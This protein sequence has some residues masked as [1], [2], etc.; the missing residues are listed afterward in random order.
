MTTTD[1]PRWTRWQALAFAAVLVLAAVLRLGWAGVNSFAF[2]EARLS[3]ISLDMARDGVFAT[4]GMPS[5]AGVPN[6]PA[7]AWIYALPY[8]LSP[9]PLLATLFTGV[10]GVV[11]V[12]L[13]GWLARAAWGAWASVAAALFLA[14]S[15]F[16]VLYS[17]SIWAPDLLP[18]LGIVWA[19][20]AYKA[21]Q[22]GSAWALA[23]HIFVAGFA[24]QVHFAGAALALGS[25]WLVLRF[26]WWR[27]WRPLL[28]GAVLAGVA[29]LPFALE[30]L[31]HRPDVLDA[32]RSASGGAQV[33][34]GAFTALAQ[35]AAGQGWGYMITGQRDT[36]SQNGL[37]AAGSLLLCGV[38][39]VALLPLRRRAQDAPLP[40]ITLVLLLSG[41]VF[42]TRHSTPVFIH[43]LLAAMPALALMV[44]A[45]VT[46][47]HGRWVRAALAVLL[48]CVCGTAALWLGE[49]ITLGGRVE[50]P[51][52]LG[53]PLGISRGVAQTV[54]D[55]RVALFFTHGGD[56][57]RDG[58]AAVFAAL[59]YT[60]PHRIIG[61]DS[62]LLLPDAPATLV[63]TLE[64]FQAWEEL[65]AAGLA[66]DVQYY[67]RRE[68]EG[69][70]PFVMTAYDGQA[71]PQGF[72]L[73]QP[74]VAFA[75]GTRLLGWKVRRVGDRLRLSTL[76][77]A[78]APQAVGTMQQFHH[79]RDNATLDGDFRMGSDVPLQLHLWQ[80]GDRAVVMADFAAGD[81]VALQGALWVG[82][83]HYALESGA[84]VTLTSG[85][86]HVRLGPFDL[87]PAG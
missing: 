3:L 12:A 33:D 67:P 78:D 77:A 45:A 70:L 42:F 8:A 5:S 60:R 25:L 9:D 6:L 87:P 4:I 49:S 30:V 62:L 38:G 73:L 50:T 72:T 28:I 46:R 71:A 83:G 10:L 29:A 13:T 15:P 32:F 63:G 41:A 76:W 34:G 11:A 54:P 26:G 85:G 19:A 24:F 18:V 59:W 40:E 79:L 7:A 39:L 2:D 1:A 74:E 52:G 20:A 66:D 69:V 43:Y 37:Y 31:L 65:V 16:A 68:G 44:G 61:G 86:D 58:E 56:P 47:W 75:D 23:L 51:G 48:I 36:V 84:R 27:R 80:V 81:V 57:L 35:L 17:R 53:T 82:V 55:D 22:R 14:A 64:P 21:A